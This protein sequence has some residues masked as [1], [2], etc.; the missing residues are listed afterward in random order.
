MKLGF[1]SI[2]QRGFDWEWA[3]QQFETSK[4]LLSQLG[5]P[6]VAPEGSV[7][8]P[9]AMSNVLDRFISE[10]VD[11]VIVQNGTFAWGGH[12]VNI[13]Q[14]TDCP[15]FLWALP[16]PTL[17]GRLRS[18]SLCGVNMNSSALYR[19]GRFYKYVYAPADSDAALNAIRSFAK[20]VNTACRLR[21]TRIALVGYRVPG[22]YG[23]TF[24]ELGLR[25]QIGPEV[26][27]IGMAEVARKMESL[28]SEEVNRV[29]N[30]YYER[31]GGEDIG[32]ERMERL[33]RACAALDALCRQYG[34]SALAVKCWPDARETLGTS[35]CS[36]MSKLTDDGMMAG[37]EADMYGTVTMLMQYYLTGKP[38]FLVDF[39]YADAD[40]D[41]GVMWHCGNAP[42]SLADDKSK[43]RI[44]EW[45]RSFFGLKPGPFTFAKLGTDN[46]F[47][48]LLTKGEALKSE[49]VFNGTTSVGRF[50]TPVMKLLDAI[51]Y[52]GWEHHFSVVYE[53]VYQ[54]ML[55]LCRLL[56]IKPVEV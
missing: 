33:A 22:F 32:P 6:F 47:R 26:H 29:L 52:G 2:A 20:V 49:M 9:E 51:I 17:G 39:V 13:A 34:C 5:T 41:T 15:L 43:V 31:I 40:Q 16:E 18:N 8:T 25:K 11:A 19:L 45:P 3:N 23:S 53:D 1:V 7:D 12:I 37:C 10:R 38:P 24:D 56:G 48:M 4:R 28:S 36:V 30:E 27:H 54:E 21:S 14:T 55:D 35:V 50:R 42:F 44:S 46:G